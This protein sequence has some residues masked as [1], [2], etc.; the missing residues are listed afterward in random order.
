MN[1]FWY[2]QSCFKFQDDKL[3]LLTDP[4]TPQEVG[5]TSP[6]L[7]SNLDLILF[8]APKEN[9][10]LENKNSLEKFFI[11]ST[12]GEYEI[13]NF[14]VY[15]LPH[16]EKRQGLKII[17]SLETKGIKIVFLGKIS[18]LLNE[19][20]LEEI[21]H[22]DFLIIPVGGQEVLNIEEACKVI[23]QIEPKVIIPS[24]YQIVGQRSNLEKVD[25]FVH[26]LGLKKVEVLDKLKIQKINAEEKETKVFILKPVS[27]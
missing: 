11:I 12:P 14:F 18:E 23:I 8:S 6:R 26:T 10:F 3:T 21:N 25:K 27:V 5:L 20:E 13:K 16:F 19:R 7:S 24:C 9:L 17:Y 15:G 4:F 2:G 22:P 1:L